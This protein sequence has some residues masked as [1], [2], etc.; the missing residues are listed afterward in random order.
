MNHLLWYSSNARAWT[1]ALPIGCARLGAMIFGRDGLVSPGLI[2][3][4]S[5]SPAAQSRDMDTL[6]PPL[7]DGQREKIPL[8][9]DTLWHWYC[10][11][12]Q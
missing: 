4:G 6:F 11:L 3:P 9:L 5:C 10:Y 2:S 12:I 7:T 1:D 8:N